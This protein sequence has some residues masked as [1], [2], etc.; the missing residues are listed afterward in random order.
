MEASGFGG[1]VSLSAYFDEAPTAIWLR[2]FIYPDCRAV[3]RLQPRDYWSRF[4][5]LVE[6]IRQNLPNK[7]VILSR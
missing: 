2:C 6:I 5:T 4:Q 1:M 3:I 7:L